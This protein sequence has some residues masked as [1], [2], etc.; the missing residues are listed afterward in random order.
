MLYSPIVELDQIFGLFHLA[1]SL[2]AQRLRVQREYVLELVGRPFDEERGRVHINDNSNV[3]R[4]FDRSA[5]NQRTRNTATSTK[6]ERT[7]CGVGG[8]GGCSSWID[9][10]D[11]DRFDSTVLGVRFE[12]F[13]QI[14]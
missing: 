1:L 8:G 13:F 6:T 4:V 12:N 3:L 5:D 11:S 2:Q 14:M 10:R 7:Y 9:T